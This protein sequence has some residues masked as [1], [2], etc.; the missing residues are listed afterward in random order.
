MNSVPPASPERLAQRQLDAYN[1]RDVEA[2][3][4]CYAEDVDV[5]DLRTNDPILR[6]RAALHERYGKMFAATPDL[7][8]EV[9]TRI[10]CGPFAFDHEQVTRNGGRS[11]VVA[12]YE[13]K[14]GL[15]F[16][17]WFARP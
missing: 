15:I 13:V 5:R 2:F 9:G 11:E 8:A 17:V 1:A 7:R 10:T 6:G 12:I 14:D 3:A 4:A 16:R